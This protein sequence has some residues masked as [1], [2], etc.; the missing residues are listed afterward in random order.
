M[1]LG[2]GLS[3]VTTQYQLGAALFGSVTEFA[4]MKPCVTNSYGS[5]TTSELDT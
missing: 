3:P 2:T 5:C 4:T 1:I